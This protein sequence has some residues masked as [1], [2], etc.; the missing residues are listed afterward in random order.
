MCSKIQAMRALLV[1]FALLFAATPSP[2]AKHQKTPKSA[3]AKG[4]KTKRGGKATKANHMK[5]A[6]KNRPKAK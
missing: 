3:N 5:K 1:V 6:N 2:A 4:Y